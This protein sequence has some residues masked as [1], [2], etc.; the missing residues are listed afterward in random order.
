MPPL[1]GRWHGVSRDG[2]VAAPVSPM[3]HLEGKWRSFVQKM[4]VVREFCGA[5][6]VA[7]GPLCERLIWTAQSRTCGL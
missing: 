1:E 4:L 2:E 5:G 6:G 3:P 7:Y